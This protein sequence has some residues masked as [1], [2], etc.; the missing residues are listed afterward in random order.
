MSIEDRDWF[1]EDYRERERKYGGDFSLHSTPKN[2]PGRPEKRNGNALPIA[3]LNI[4]AAFSCALSLYASIMIE[5]EQL[6]G[7]SWPSL[8]AAILCWILFAVVYN[9]NK[10]KNRGFI[11]SLSLAVCFISA[12]AASGI[13][14]F[15]TVRL[16]IGAYAAGG[17]QSEMPVFN[18]ITM[19]HISSNT[20]IILFIAA[21]ASIPIYRNYQAKKRARELIDGAVVMTPEQFMRLKGNYGFSPHLDC[22]GVY[23]LYN[24]DKNKYYVGQSQHVLTRVNQHFTGHGGNGDVYADYKYHDHFEIRIVKFEGS[25]FRTLNEMERRAIDT[26]HAFSCGYNKTRGNRD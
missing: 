14:S 9:N 22:P 10:R 4:F 25:G 15:L 6:N 2:R 26:Y 11:C 24:R 5:R 1:R 20:L 18:S 12:L 7:N 23:V 13:A 3:L 21:C 16:F 17:V 19:P 8:I